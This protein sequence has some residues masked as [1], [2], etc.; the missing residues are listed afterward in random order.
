[1]HRLSHCIFLFI[2]AA[3]LCLVTQAEAQ[4]KKKPQA[5]FGYEVNEELYPQQT[6]EAAMK[7]IVAALNR[8]K[9]AYILA[10]IADPVYVDY[11]VDRYKAEIQKGNDEAKRLVAFDRLVQETERY[12]EKDPQI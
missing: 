6:P 12:Y 4:P 10:Q 9:L 7:S 5:R 1:M 8:N 11:W 2:V 3:A